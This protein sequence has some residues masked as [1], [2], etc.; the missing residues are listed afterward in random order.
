MHKNGMRPLWVCSSFKPASE[1]S[2]GI[3]KECFMFSFRNCNDQP[4][5]FQLSSLFIYHPCIKLIESIQ[6]IKEDLNR[7]KFKITEYT[8]RL[9]TM[10]DY[11]KLQKYM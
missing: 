6:K 9:R 5:I 7:K 10:R 11:P 4:Q 8:E 1:T 2:S 3:H